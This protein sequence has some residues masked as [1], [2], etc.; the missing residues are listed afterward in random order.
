MPIVNG[1]TDFNHP[2]QVLTDLFSILE[3]LSPEAIDLEALKD[4][5]V[6]FY[7]DTASNMAN[8]WILAAAYLDFDLVL[9]GPKGYEPKDTI[10]NALKAKGLN[11]RHTF[12]SDAQKASEDADVLYTD[13]WVSMGDEAEANQ[14]KTTLQD[15][16]VNQTLLS[17]AKTNAL[18]LHCLPAHINEEVT[19]AV[20]EGPNSIVYDQAENRLHT[21]KAIL[22]QLKS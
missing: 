11:S 12:E 17:K 21:Q 3:H 22:A 19:E 9:A 2:C 1:L 13:V 7:G 5:K 4:K 6:V 16:Q 10:L 18:F 14:R 15:F 8:S 20:I